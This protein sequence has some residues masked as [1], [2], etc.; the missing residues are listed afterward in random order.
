[1]SDVKLLPKRIDQDEHHY[2]T[3]NDVPTFRDD[4]K[5]NELLV[6]VK[7][8][9]GVLVKISNSMAAKPNVPPKPANDNIGNTGNLSLDMYSLAFDIIICILKSYLNNM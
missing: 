3:V 2:V 6:R 4:E 7:R 5:I 1:M 9:E 8:M